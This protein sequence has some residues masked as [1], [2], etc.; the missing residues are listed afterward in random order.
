MEH[1]RSPIPEL[2]IANWRTEIL[3][4]RTIGKSVCEAS[5][6][7]MLSNVVV[8]VH[9]IAGE[10]NLKCLLNQRDANKNNLLGT[11]TTR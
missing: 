1:R 3:D 6:V 11:I 4:R 9:E 5:L 8:Q 10:A 7:Q 2:A